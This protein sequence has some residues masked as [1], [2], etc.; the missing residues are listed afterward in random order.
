LADQ[1]YSYK[2]VYT[3]Y[4]NDGSTKS[5]EIPFESES[6][7]PEHIFLEELLPYLNRLDKEYRELPDFKGLTSQVV[8]A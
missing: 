1:K 6:S 3:V 8:K 7:E 5:G 2:I 4:F